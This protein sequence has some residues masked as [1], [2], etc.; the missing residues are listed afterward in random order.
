MVVRTL[1]AMADKGMYD[2]VEG[3]FFRY[4]T[5]EMWS[6]PHYEKMCEDNAQLARLYLAAAELT[7]TKRYQQKAEHVLK[8]VMKRLCDPER[9]IFFNSQDADEAYYTANADDRK[10]M[11]M[12]KVDK[13]VFT[14]TN[15]MM[16]T[17]FLRAWAC[18]DDP[19]YRDIA[20]RNIEFLSTRMRAPDGAF[21]HY[22]DGEPHRE[23]LLRDQLWMAR[24][25]LEA[26]E[27]IGLPEYLAKAEEVCQLIL[28]RYWDRGQKGVLDRLITPA[29]VGELKHS[30]KELVENSLFA[31]TLCRLSYI[32][33]EKSYHT[34][35]ET[36]VRNFPDYLGQY[37]HFT[38]QYALAVSR[39][40]RPPTEIM[41]ISKVGQAPEPIRQAAYK[42]FHSRKTVRH[43]TQDVAQSE[44][45]IQVKKVPAAVIC[46]ENEC[47]EPAF[48]PQEVLSRI[49]SLR[50]PE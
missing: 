8:W 4:A 22:Y 21:Y 1:D 48:T 38:A 16:S 27:A 31:E 3:G 10:K 49:N 18:A 37:G 23:G 15:A 44:K 46:L 50:G 35:A 20:V 2:A 47:L 41:L 34:R 25:F 33:P 36:I 24:L 42:V 13:T 9:G 14:D 26:Y 28:Q 30:K 12:P 7:Q 19:R 11:N 39:L 40:L 6:T 5:T 32:L 45:K 17:A 43:M 29:D